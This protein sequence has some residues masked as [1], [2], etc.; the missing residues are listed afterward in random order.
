MARLFN[1]SEAANIGIHSM[2]IIAAS[3]TNLNSLQISDRLNFSRNHVAK[4]LQVLSR[5]NLISL[6]REPQ[7]GFKHKKPQYRNLVL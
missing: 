4:V 1:I 5:Y 6:T 3:N 7:G 2:T